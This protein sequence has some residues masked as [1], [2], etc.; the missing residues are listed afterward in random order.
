MSDIQSTTRAAAGAAA[1]DRALIVFGLLAYLGG[2]LSAVY[3]P[4]GVI[5]VPVALLFGA[6]AIHRAGERR[7]WVPVGLS[8][9]GG[10]FTLLWFALMAHETGLFQGVLCP[11][12][13]EN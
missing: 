5:G 4:L 8:V 13:C 7:Q 12:A 3:I 9:L 6:L 2:G 11:A 1:S 10:L